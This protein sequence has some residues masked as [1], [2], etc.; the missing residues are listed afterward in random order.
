VDEHAIQ[1]VDLTELLA[2]GDDDRRV[3][4]CCR[5]VVEDV[6]VG[7][8]DAGTRETDSRESV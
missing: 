6:V 4:F 2:L 3:A 5:F 1:E 7:D 8:L